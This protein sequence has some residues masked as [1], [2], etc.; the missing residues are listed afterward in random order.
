VSEAELLRLTGAESIDY[1]VRSHRHGASWADKDYQAF[2]IVDPRIGAAVWP[3]IV[4][5]E[6]DTKAEARQGAFDKWE[7]TKAERARYGKATRALYEYREDE[8]TEQ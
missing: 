4:G 7:H 5:P 2:I 3:N 8:R 1:D 6:S